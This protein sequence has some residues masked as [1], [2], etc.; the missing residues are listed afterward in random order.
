MVY[1]TTETNLC[2]PGPE[3]WECS[4]NKA[5]VRC[6]S[7]V[8]Q[9]VLAFMTVF[10]RGLATR[11]EIRFSRHPIKG[12]LQSL[13]CIFLIHGFHREKPFSHPRPKRNLQVAHD[14]HTRPLSTT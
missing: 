13:R 6:T 10:N 5:V 11:W 7:A 8:G 9:M 2:P 1:C 3:I 12:M 14:D 4:T